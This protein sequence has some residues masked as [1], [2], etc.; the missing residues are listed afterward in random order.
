M[1]AANS[2]DLPF[3]ARPIQDGPGLKVHQLEPFIRTTTLSVVAATMS[4]LPS[5]LRSPTASELQ[6]S[7]VEKDCGRRNVPSPLPSNTSTS[8][9]TSAHTARSA[10]PSRLKEP[11]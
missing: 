11:T 10:F 4:I 2:A 1:R 9:E 5:R 8:A 7:P 6:K 3:D